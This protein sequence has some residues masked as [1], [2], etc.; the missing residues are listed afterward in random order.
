LSGKAA[1]RCITREKS[2]HVVAAAAFCRL[3]G[4][5]GFSSFGRSAG[6]DGFVASLI[7]KIEIE[8][9]PKAAQEFPCLRPV[10]NF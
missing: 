5:R 7:G 2:S 8:H 9:E 1:K 3:A 10:P 6:P 4:I